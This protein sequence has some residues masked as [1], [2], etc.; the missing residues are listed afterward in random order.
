MMREHDDNRLSD[1]VNFG[2]NG[3]EANA[4]MSI[5]NRREAG[6][7]AIGP[8]AR[9]AAGLMAIALVVAFNQ[10]S[11]PRTSVLG[12][13]VRRCEVDGV[14]VAQGPRVVKAE[15]AT[16]S[17]RGGRAGAV[18]VPPVKLKPGAA[19]APR[20]V[21][22]ALG[23][24]AE[25]PGTLIVTALVENH[26]T[27]PVAVQPIQVTARHGA[28]VLER[29]ADL[30]GGSVTLDPGKSVAAITHV[31]AEADGSWKFD[32]STTA[33]VGAGVITAVAV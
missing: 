13:K 4:S 14:P 18:L 10:T 30:G 5:R 3:K 21:T 27:C 7:A 15:S 29:I 19:E 20:P 8:T 24:R 26:A 17:I 22:L 11:K 2:R 32:A 16:A 31:P 33:D 12:T 6:F 25:S 28:T 9:I 23:I 1:W